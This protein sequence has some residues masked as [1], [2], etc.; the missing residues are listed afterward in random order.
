MKECLPRDAEASPERRRQVTLK[1]PQIVVGAHRCRGP[2]IRIP[3]C[4]AQQQIIRNGNSYR[5]RTVLLRPDPVTSTVRVCAR[6]SADLHLITNRTLP[7]V[8][9]TVMGVGRVACLRQEHDA[10]QRRQ[11]WQTVNRTNGRLCDLFEFMLGTVPPRC[12]K[13]G[14]PATE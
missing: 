13:R 6:G 1:I 3:P 10:L 14:P 5:R 4:G 11:E 12:G 2:Y 9:F 7:K 8:N